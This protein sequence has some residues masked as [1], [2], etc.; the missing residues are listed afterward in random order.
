MEDEHESKVQC[1]L[2]DSAGEVYPAK[3]ID[4]TEAGLILE[5]DAEL[6]D[7]GVFEDKHQDTRILQMKGFRWYLIPEYFLVKEQH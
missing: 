2:K 5:V 4:R 7:E 1:V 6:V 3:I